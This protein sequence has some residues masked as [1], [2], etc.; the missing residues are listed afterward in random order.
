MTE[1]TKE[2][3]IPQEIPGRTMLKKNITPERALAEFKVAV[4]IWLSYMA[5]GDKRKALA[6]VEAKIAERAT[7]Q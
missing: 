6:L 7:L 5:E 2:K 3:K 1:E 4:D